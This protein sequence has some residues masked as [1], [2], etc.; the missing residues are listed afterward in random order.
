M[1]YLMPDGDG[2]RDEAANGSSGVNTGKADSYV[3]IFDNVQ[4]NYREFRRRAEMYRKKMDLANRSKETVYNI[5]TML[6]GRAWDLIED[7]DIEQLDSDGFNKVFARLDAAFHFDPLTELPSDFE[8]FFMK[9][10]RRSGQTLQEYNQEFT[11]TERRLRTTHGVD[12]PE[13]VKAWYYLRKS[14]L[15]KEQ[16]LMV[17]SSVGHANLTLENVQKTMNFMI[18]QDAKLET[19][20]G[21]WS[22][23]KADAY[24]QRDESTPWQESETWDWSQDNMFWQDDESSSQ[25]PDHDADYF[26]D[27]VLAAEEDED[28][29]DYDVDE[30][31]S[32][33]A[34]FVEAKSKLNQMRTNRGF[35]PVVALVD[36]GGKSYGSKGQKGKKSK[37]RGKSSKGRPGKGPNP[38]ARA[39]AAM[40]STGSKA[41][42]RCGGHG[43]LARNCPAA[44]S[45]KKRKAEDDD[46]NMVETYDMTEGDDDGY[47]ESS[48]VA[49]QDG[50]AA[51]FLSSYHQMR[52]YLRF[53]AEKG[54]DMSTI[55]VYDCRKGFRYGNS[56]K[57]VSTKCILLPTFA[58]QKRRDVLCYLVG[59]T[60][61]ILLG[62]PML[63]KLGLVV[64]YATRKIKWQGRPWKKVD[65]GAKDEYLIHLCE[66]MDEL[67]NQEWH[68]PEVLLPDDSEE[69]VDFSKNLGY[70]GIMDSEEAVHLAHGEETTWD[71]EVGDASSDVSQT[72]PREDEYTPEK[73]AETAEFQ[74]TD[75]E[76]DGLPEELPAVPHERKEDGTAEMH[77]IEEPNHEERR[78][79]EHVEF[80]YRLE[81]PKVVKRLTAP[82]MRKMVKQA[83]NAVQQKNQSLRKASTLGNRL[84]QPKRKVWEIF[85]GKGR[86]NRC[87]EKRDDIDVESYSYQNG[88]DFERAEDRK[89]FY[90]RLRDEEPDEILISPPCRLWSLLQELSACRSDEAR[91]KLV[92]ERRANHRTILD[93]TATVFEFQRRNGRHATAE[94]PKTSRASRAWK[95]RN[96]QKMRGYDTPVDQ[97]AYGLTLPGD[98]GNWYPAKKPTIFR[99]TKKSLYNG[100]IR[101]CPGCPYHIP[102]EGY[103]KGYGPRSS[104]AEDYPPRLANKLASL[105]AADPEDCDDDF[106]MPVDDASGDM[107]GL[108]GSLMED[109]KKIDDD[110]I[111][112]NQQLRA[113]VGVPAYNYIKR[114]HKSLGHPQPAVL[115][116]MLTEVQA[117]EAVLKAAENFKCVTCYHRKKP[118]TV[119]PAAGLTATTFNNRIM[120]DSAWI[121]T[122]D[123]RKCVV[124]FMDHASRYVTIRILKSERSEEFLKGLERAWIKTFGI[125]HILRVDEAKG[126]ASQAVR[127]WCSDRGIILEVA[128]GEAHNWLAPLERKHQVVRQALEYYMADRGS[129]K[130][131]TLEE[132]CIY[133]PHQV[134]S[135]S[136][137][138]GFTP[139]QWVFGKTPMSVQSLT[140]EL[141]NPGIDPLDGQSKFAVLQEK[142]VAAQHAWIKA[143]SDAK[144]RRAMNKIYNEYKDE[145][146][147]GQLVWYWRKQGTSILQK[148][149][150]RGPARVVAKKLMKLADL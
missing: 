57:E 142:R 89:D 21:R 19:S 24:Y 74:S 103:A 139:S 144:L 121:D 47:M 53:L 35:Y 54:Y 55:E 67:H 85:V 110:L 13:K 95:T 68:E 137:V 62:R 118:F 46:I 75:E 84:T 7:L 105:L 30:Y 143:D 113:E 29:D 97:C 82:M 50:G 106:I 40:G 107:T 51:S 147:V 115:K 33:Y 37:G 27:S 20:G 8:A 114:L 116:K 104:M 17:M 23:S 109:R 34:N 38:K 117:T 90:R 64:N 150:W 120:A 11:H 15:T 132:A 14:G 12:L 42:L 77:G 99:T 63:E 140:A 108:D 26:D 102:I 72:I 18:G 10:S 96:F 48:D 101:K 98:D 149:K 88:W 5:V 78:I 131:S 22:R 39:R 80:I 146:Q 58:G 128:P 79:L 127:D 45:D 133:V 148:A 69:H 91:E 119:P 141:F 41:C 6:T 16:R 43:H 59:G 9:L 93:F 138:N 70:W 60:C 135:M 36:N 66:D 65:L 112:L 129:F 44:G 122:Q 126:W 3:P 125:P 100:L 49:V 94:H 73:E 61:P 136:F 32:I 145:V 52:K 2:G 86:V 4:R 25:W 87:L 76:A 1:R 56:E 111:K 28:E 81:D 71:P 124:T 92:R 31:D 134:N 83:E 123:G 130:L